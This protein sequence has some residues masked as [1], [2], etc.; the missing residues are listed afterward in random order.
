MIKIKFDYSNKKLIAISV[1]GHA[2]YAKHGHDIVCAAVSTA[3]VVTANAIEHLKL[4]H[5][6]E[7][8]VEQGDFKLFLKEEDDIVL[9]LT[10]NLRLTLI[11]LQKQYPKYIKNQK[12]G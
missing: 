1:K 11:D 12:E 9:S 8:N 3:I 2:N 4:K 7:L 6:I 10:E 5:K